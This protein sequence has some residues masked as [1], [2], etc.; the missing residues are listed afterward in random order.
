MEYAEVTEARAPLAVATLPVVR[1][2]IS[3]LRHSEKRV[4][5]IH[6]RPEW[7]GEPSFR[8]GDDLVNVRACPSALAVRDAITQHT[9]GYLVVLTDVDDADLGLAIRARLV[10]ERLT[11][12]RPWEMVK[13][14]FDAPVLD[15]LLVAEH[16]AASALTGWEPAGGWAKAPG[17][18]LTRDH[19]LGHLASVVFG[20]SREGIPYLT[21]G[22]P[23][24][25]SI[26]RWSLDPIA[27]ARLE[28]LA[29]DIRDGLIHW[30][31]ESTG[32][33]GTWTLR[34]VQMGHG[35]DAL[36]LAL[37]S[38]LLWPE[39]GK[40]P[41]SV[42]EARGLVRARIGGADLR[43]DQAQSWSRAAT[44]LLGQLDHPDSLLE[45]TET[46]LGE[47]NAEALLER[48]LI[49]PGSYALRL[50]AFARSVRRALPDPGEAALHAVEKAY[51]ELMEHDL[52]TS[53]LAEGLA[54]AEH[55]ESISD[56]RARVARMALRLVRWL[57]LPEEHARTLTDALNEQVRSG[58]YVEWAFA[59]VWTGDSDREVG[60]AYRELLDE[61]AKRRDERDRR[62]ATQLSL[63]IEADSDPGTLIPIE[64]ALTT[65][66]RPL[67]KSLLVVLDGMSAGVLAELADE[68]T[69]RRWTEF[70]D[71]TLGHRRVLLPVLPTVTEACRT[72]LL[73]GSLRT[74]GQSEEKS[75]FPGAVGDPH[76]RLFHKDDLRAPGGHKLAPEVKAAIDGR[77]RIVGVVLNAIDDSLDKMDPGG[78][79][80]DLDAVQHLEPLVEAARTAGRLLILTSDHGHVVHR[81][82]ILCS[83]SSAQ[84]ARW[85][86][87]HGPLTD[88]E[89]SVRGRRVLLGGGDIVLAWREDLRYT[90]KRA[91]YHGGA[92]ASEVAVPFAV[93]SP[94]PEMKV[95][96]WG[97]APAQEPVWWN[98][99]VISGR[100]K[101]LDSSM[102]ST[103]K[104]EEG[105]LLSVEEVTS[106]EPRWAR[107]LDELLASD[108]YAEQRVRAGRS[109]PDDGRVRAV[110]EGLLANGGRLHESTLSAV[111]Q[112]PAARLRN[113]LAAVRRVLSVDGYDP[114]SY[115]PDGVTVLLSTDT[116]AEQ[117]GV[118]GP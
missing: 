77:A 7:L 93:F 114:I 5:G 105:A 47:F 106:T 107:F 27:V 38:G 116:L 73:T 112:V 35:G 95:P 56:P 13:Q 68:L 109:A 75:A 36:P 70:V 100:R 76:A 3:K 61:V 22:Y 14:S 39:K 115:D 104:E 63:V 10:H 90:G 57:T 84:S 86:P 12:L 91:G 89:I 79:V 33:A 58:G 41:S 40:I 113:V 51:A 11:A 31:S 4:V 9:V 42:T 48:S 111:A 67:G 6:A 74:G 49:L 29:E 43:P 72:S 99:T 55:D 71:Q 110:L 19:A 46:L 18:A 54:G 45:R 82:G 102:T 103:P 78:T 92:S 17:G 37:I 20:S 98:S 66:V 2:I 117:F 94:T 80:W 34:A 32:P 53:G 21:P 23:D 25:I 1:R 83:G 59:D 108:R 60:K 52:A 64:S 87:A 24:A 118:P 50:R 85:R 26:L 62:L 88:G 28:G 69:R 65:L 8:L 15:P 16:W 96:G 81:D 97:P 30:L 101:P 44:A